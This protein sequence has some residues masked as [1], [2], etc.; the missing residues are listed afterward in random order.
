MTT[1]TKHFVTFLSAGTL[2]AEQSTKEI[3]SWNTDRAIELSRSVV[4]RYETRPYAFYF[5]TRERG[6][7][8]FDSKETAKSNLYFLGG[9]IL[10]LEQ[11]KARSDSDDNSILIFNMEA[12]GYEKVIETCRP[13]R[14]TAAFKPGDVVLDVEDE[15]T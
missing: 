9:T 10:T 13:Y 1:M 3:D 4:E 7:D 14:F 2:V 8:D 11:I 5:T 15:I 6:P 12:N